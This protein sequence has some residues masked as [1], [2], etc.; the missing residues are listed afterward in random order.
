M[1]DPVLAIDI[2]G[3]KIL[4]A[5]VSGAYVIDRRV[6]ATVRGASAEQWC[7]AIAEAV[8]PWKG[9]YAQAGAAVTGAIRQGRWYAVNPE[10]LPVPA[11]FDLADQLAN[12]IGVPVH[13]ANDAHAAAWG[14]YRHGAG[15][16]RNLAFVTISTGIGGGLVLGG[17]LVEG[18]SGLAG[19][20]GLLPAPGEGGLTRIENLTSGRWL[21]TAAAGRA[22]DARA[23]FAAAEA[24]AGWA[25]D[26]IDQSL[27]RAAN[28]LQTLQWVID[29]DVIVIG[30]GIGLAP[31]YFAGLRQRLDT[32]HAT[33]LVSAQLG[34]DA[35]IIGAADLAIAAVVG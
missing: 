5:L 32:V 4:A 18:L 17:K 26:L 12:R 25:R 1:S 22:S 13:C 31:R 14:E 2:G 8:A 16:G 19:H 33:T 24:G 27:D 9:R 10:T 35:G 7:D 23:V 28:V 6:L 20:V 15:Q 11:G 34:G 30:G 21:A 3:T 29:P